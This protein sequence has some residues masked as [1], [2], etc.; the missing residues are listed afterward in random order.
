[1]SAGPHPHALSRLA[2]FSRI[3]WY[4]RVYG[5][6]RKPITRATS[7]APIDQGI[8]SARLT[9]NGTHL[10]QRESVRKA[11]DTCRLTREKPAGIERG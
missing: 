3:R 7:Q 4:S 5:L 11:A 10:L 8:A 1:M 6:A 9:V 2:A